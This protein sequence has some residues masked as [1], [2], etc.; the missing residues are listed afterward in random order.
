MPEAAWLSDTEMLT[1]LLACV[2]TKRQRVRVPETP[3]HLDVL[4]ADQP[5]VGGLEP[6]LGSQHLRTLTVIG[7]PNGNATLLETAPG[8]SVGE[9]MA[10]TEAELIVGDSVPEMK[11]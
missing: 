10:V 6:R 3:M 8:V 7:F 2:S 1:Y 5:L 11:I 9:V 4:L